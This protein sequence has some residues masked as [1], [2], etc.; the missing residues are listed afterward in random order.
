MTTLND[1]INPDR[2]LSKTTQR[3]VNTIDGVLEQSFNVKAYGLLIGAELNLYVNRKKVEPTTTV[4]ISGTN[5]TR[6]VTNVVLRD[7][8]SETFST[9]NKG[10]VDFIFYYREDLSNFSGQGETK[11]Q[12]YLDR[13]TGEVELI[14]VDKASVNTTTLTD[15]DINNARCVA[16]CKLNRSY[17]PLKTQIND[18][19]IIERESSNR[20]ISTLP[21]TSNNLTS[22]TLIRSS[23]NVISN[24][25]LQRS[26]IG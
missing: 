10:E 23:N 8:P 9:D 19:I 16:N 13:N 18:V 21:G 5:N 7:R 6:N 24:T 2:I 22:N 11:L 3:I 15:S 25:S 1:L 4:T 26:L 20:P 14:I 12:E 17:N